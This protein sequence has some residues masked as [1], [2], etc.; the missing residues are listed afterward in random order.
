MR[1]F[2]KITIDNVNRG[3]DNIN[4]NE[5]ILALDQGTTSSRAIIFDSNGSGLN[6]SQA[7]FTQYTPKE[8]W[9]EHDARE[10][11]ESQLSVAK[12]VL[13]DLKGGAGAISAIG[14]TN[15]RETTIL[16][17][18][19]SGEPVGHAIVWQCRRSTE[20]CK[21]LKD[22]GHEEFLRTRTGLMLDP[23]FSATKIKWMLEEIP[24][25]AK[26]AENG[27]ILFG[28]VD[29]WLLWNLTG[30]KVHATDVS[31]ASR[32]MLM[33]IESGKWDSEILKIM[34]IPSSILPEI[35]P[36]VGYF[37]DTDASIFGSSIPITGIAGDQHAALFGHRA[38]EPGDVK[39]TY[40]TGCFMLMNVG[41][42]PIISPGGL[43]TTVAWGI[44]DK[45]VYALEGSVF[46]AGAVLQWLRDDLGLV[47]NVQEIDR[48]SEEIDDTGG[49]YLVPA[50][51][52]LGTPWWSTT[53]KGSLIGLT[54]ASKKN[55]VCR[56]F[57][58]S[59]AY[60]SRDVIDV[61]ISD[62]GHSLRRMR[63]DGGVTNSDILMQ[64]QADLLGIPVER[65]PSVEVTALGAALMAG[66]GAGMWKN[67]DDLKGLPDEDT[68]F[69]PRMSEERR[70]QLY[71]GWLE[72]VRK[73]T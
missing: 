13:K 44:G 34:E 11:W 23:Y 39:N 70:K 67:L 32:T 57:L 73:I 43:L 1:F 4:M 42:K 64:F 30:G 19:I 38:F 15:Q 20:I 50:Y 49:L 28:T 21:R 65:P 46:M 63:V 33:N 17:D 22:A 35:R 36:S 37:G 52:G 2:R 27:E 40:G 61:M 59:I 72:T 14:I 60:R 18:R 29:T 55:H 5:Y 62:S 54:R 51:Q 12:K 41:D 16:W 9:V 53:A 31:N 6:S 3:K 24:G 7:E 71:N 48:L 8:S 10:I 68:V 58:E 56:A 47:Q 25:L 69:H 66:L 26:R 45:L